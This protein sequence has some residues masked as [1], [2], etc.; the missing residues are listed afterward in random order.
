MLALMKIIAMIAQ[1]GGAG[2][3]TLAIHLSTALPKK[4]KPV[5][6]IDLDP[7]ASASMWGDQREDKEPIVVATQAPR[8]NQVLDAAQEHNVR[9]VILDTAPHSEQAALTAARIANLIIIP[10]RPSI[11]DLRAMEATVDL[12]SLTKRSAAFV[13]SAALPRSRLINQ[14]RAAIEGY[15]FPVADTV[16][17]QRVA[18]S[19]SLITGQTVDEYNYKSKAA[20]E[21]KDLA[22]EIS[23]KI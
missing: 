19:H 22:Y 10:C 17:Y 20:K 23:Q 16:I 12:V 14:A 2:K 8:L 6:I 7:Q 9:T 15:R 11:L 21:I 3:T 5:V 18:F 13:I 4:L 1:K